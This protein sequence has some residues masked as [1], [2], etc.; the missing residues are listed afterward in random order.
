MTGAHMT[1]N[2]SHEASDQ[3]T[4]PAFSSCDIFVDP[5]TQ[6]PRRERL[7]QIQVQWRH[8]QIRHQGTKAGRTSCNTCLGR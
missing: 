2:N 6:T 7:R 8:F 4:C 1:H 3:G 5:Q